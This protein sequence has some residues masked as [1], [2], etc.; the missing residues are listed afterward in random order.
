MTDSQPYK[1]ADG[2][3]R[4][5]P[6]VSYRGSRLD[7]LGP[8]A[9]YRVR[10]QDGWTLTLRG[11]LDFGAYKEED[12][13]I[14][15]GLGNRKTTL[16]LGLGINRDLAS[17]W[18]VYLNVDRDVLGQ[19]NGLEANTGIA[20]R[21]GS[22]RQPLSATLSTGLRF[23]DRRWTRD[24]VGVPEDRSREDRPAYAPDSSLHPFLAA[25]IIYRVTDR[26][27]GTLALRQEWLDSVYSDSPLVADKTR[28]TSM[29]SLSY[30]F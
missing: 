15:E 17:A 10:V 30:T 24:R 18:S 11:T 1:D 23:E 19:H 12:S 22:P 20:R 4:V 3:L 7:L 13:Q 29:F 21:I 9:R 26:W 28:F 25:F 8:M 2:I 6:F 14:L 27:V 5:L 16:L